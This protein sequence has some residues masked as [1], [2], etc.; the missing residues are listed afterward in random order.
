MGEVVSAQQQLPQYQILHLCG[1]GGS[2]LPPERLGGD[3]FLIATFPTHC[4]FPSKQG[5]WGNEVFVHP[6]GS[7]LA[8]PDPRTDEWKKKKV[9]MGN[10]KQMNFSSINH[11]RESIDSRTFE[12]IDPF[13]KNSSSLGTLYPF[14]PFLLSQPLHFI[15]FSFLLL[16]FSLLFSILTP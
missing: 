9:F 2:R 4:T 5:C 6:S 3:R 10:I 16:F 12:C 7:A 1:C 15:F 8:D 13:I 14:L 11:F